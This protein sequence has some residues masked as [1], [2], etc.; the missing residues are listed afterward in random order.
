MH[1]YF[2]ANIVYTSHSNRINTT[3]NEVLT[4]YTSASRDISRPKREKIACSI[5]A[6]RIEL[7]P[8]PEPTGSIEQ[9]A[10]SMP[11]NKI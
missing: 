2:T 1:R 11:V 10:I 4:I 9:H 6:A 7:P 5:T 3:E 8:N